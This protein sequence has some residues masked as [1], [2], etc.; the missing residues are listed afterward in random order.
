MRLEL[1][2]DP[3]GY[4][5][6]TSF[7]PPA[8][9]EGYTG[10]VH[11]GIITTVLDEVMAWSLARHGIWAVTGQLTTRYRKPVMLGEATTAR[12]YL[13]RDRGRALEMRGEL[14]RDADDGLLADAT[15]MFIRVPESTA[16]EWQSRYGSFGKDELPAGNGS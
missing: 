7:V 4:G 12:G 6:F 8:R 2:P 13:L 11:G 16:S 3:D 14:R 1:F 10:M 5:V 15:A 9:T